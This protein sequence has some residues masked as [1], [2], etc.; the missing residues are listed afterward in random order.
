VA[1]A[2]TRAETGLDAAACTT[3]AVVGRGKAASGEMVFGPKVLGFQRCS[4]SND[5]VLTAYEP[6]AGPSPTDRFA[7]PSVD[8]GASE[9]TMRDSE[10][11]NGCVGVNGAGD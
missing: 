10:S 11:P 4:V 7:A 6:A 5:G 3:A 2:C 1:A 8:V 9:A